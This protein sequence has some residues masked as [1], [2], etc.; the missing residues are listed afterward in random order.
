MLQAQIVVKAIGKQVDIKY[1]GPMEYAITYFHSITWMLI[2]ANVT[3]YRTIAPVQ[4]YQNN[5]CIMI[6]PELR[7]DI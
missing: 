1:L 6:T 3:I 2:S 5:H 7:S 4:R